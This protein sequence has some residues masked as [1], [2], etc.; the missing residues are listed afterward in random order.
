MTL[1]DPPLPLLLL[2]LPA[3]IRNYGRLRLQPLSLQY[4]IGY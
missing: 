3:A 1:L 2:P 4:L